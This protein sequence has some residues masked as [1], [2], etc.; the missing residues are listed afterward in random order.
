LIF[1]PFVSGKVLLMRVLGL[2]ALGVVLGAIA[3]LSYQWAFSQSPSDAA[4]IAPS[5]RDGYSRPPAKRSIVALGTLE[6]RNGPV[7]IGSPLAG[8][9]IRRVPVEEG[10]A[11][12]A[13]QVLVELDPAMAEEELRI[14]DA[15]HTEAQERQKA[16][17]NQAE[18]R[19][20]A[21][22]L[23]LRQAKDARQH[24]VQAQ[25]KQ[26]EVAEL[27]IKQARSDLARLQKLQ[28]G[29]DPLVSA[30]QVEHQQVMLDIAVAEHTAAKVALA[31][32][33]QSLD[34][35][36]E[37]A[38]AEQ[39]AAQQALEIAERG[40][41]LAALARRV[42]L[43]RLKLDQTH[44]KAPTAGTIIGIFV[45]PGEVVAAQPLLQ[46]ADLSDMVCN[47]EIDV[48]DVPLLKDKTEASITC[49]AFH[50]K[51]LI[52]TIERV[53]NLVELARL[54]PTDPRQPVDRS[55]TTVVIGIN[56]AQA[57]E[58]LGGSAKD[59]ATALVGL[60]VDVEIPLS[61]K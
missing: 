40:T 29:N 44:V 28:Q 23:S 45:H 59:A 1:H 30:Q 54:R 52:G 3:T 17:I 4:G 26:V 58:H 22:K 20:A 35:Q 11:V 16:E 47:A 60:Q 48:A 25:A 39:Q 38:D 10:Q 2:V 53:R 15:Q 18:R 51:K 50:G 12:T 61:G 57:M 56:A 37:K 8:Y 9:Q 33:E 27:K 46:I 34:F 19:L 14:A 36:L 55:V 32:L 41:G 13:G 21:A 7:S 24:E 6:P 49:R 5:L 43:A 42:E 31:R